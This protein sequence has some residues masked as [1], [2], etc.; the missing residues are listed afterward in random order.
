MTRRF[1]CRWLALPTVLL[2][3]T[4]GLTATPAAATTP[5]WVD[6]TYGVSGVADLPA[7]NLFGATTVDSLGRAV[8]LSPTVA[9]RSSDQITRMTAAGAVDSTF[10]TNGTFVLPAA[11]FYSQVVVGPSGNIYALGSNAASAAASSQLVITELTA[12]GAPVATFGTGGTATIAATAIGAPS[13]TFAEMTVRNDGDIVGNLLAQSP[14][15]AA[16]LFALTATGVLDTTFGQAAN[17]GRI[18]FAPGTSVFSPKATTAG[19]SVGVIVVNA[20]SATPAFGVEVY[21]STG[22]VTG[23]GGM[24]PLVAPAALQSAADGT[25][26]VTGQSGSSVFLAHFLASGALDTGFGTGGVVTGPAET[27]SPIGGEIEVTGTTVYVVATFSDTSTSCLPAPALVMRFA[28]GHIDSTFAGGEVAID[29][30]STFTVFGP[31]GGGLQPDGHLLVGVNGSTDPA[32]KTA[33]SAVVR[34]NISPTPPSVEAFVQ[35]FDD[36]F[37]SAEQVALN[38]G[39]FTGVPAPV[40]DSAGQTDVFLLGANAHLYVSGRVGPSWSNPV[41]I[42]AAVPGAPLVNTSP[43]AVLDGSTLHVFALNPTSNDLIDYHNDG[44]GGAWLTTDVTAVDPGAPKIAGTLSA[45]RLG[46]VM[47]VYGTT[48]GG[49]L[50]EVDNDNLAG[51]QWNFYDETMGAGGGVA[52]AG[53]PGALLI[54]GIP[55]VYGRAGGSNDL[56]EFVADHLGGRI[57]NAYDQTHSAPGS[58]TLSGNPKPVLI[59]GIPHVYVDDSS[60]GDLVEFV[61]DHQQGRIW[62]SYDQTTTSNAP[63]LT[64]NPSVVLVDGT[65]YGQAGTQVPEVF[66]NAFGTL[67]VVAA[68][69]QLN[70]I[71]NTLDVTGLSGGSAVIG[72]PSAITNGDTPIAV[73]LT[74]ATGSISSSSAKSAARGTKPLAVRPGVGAP[75]A[76]ATIGKFA[77]IPGISRL[78]AG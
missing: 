31:N 39:T 75:A 76:H 21:S 11:T 63:R 20:Q 25:F 71:W 35:G 12:G 16:F 54:G 22:A 23:S 48:A 66:E 14:T 15:Q 59:G 77:Q 9:A 2:V 36:T 49:D 78:L 68:D 46:G 26:Y 32:V 10:G 37:F 45:V 33:N 69:H 43:Q 27:C 61:A 58:P 55:H 44:A 4:L 62:N 47:H 41:D 73:S 17:P 7:P 1:G 28:G 64:G 18:V 30:L 60:N 40:V 29:F 8:V 52:L 57:W 24:P 50:I 42:T 72:D 13:F 74:V 51:H 38:P 67:A 65:K 56:I 53:A 3:A 19:N 6:I 34:L 70:H 5:A